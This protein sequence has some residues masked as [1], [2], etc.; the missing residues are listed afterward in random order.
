MGKKVKI[1]LACGSGIA[2][3]TVAA[4][5]VKKIAKAEGIEC[6]IIKCRV[7]ELISKAKNKEVDIVLSTGKIHEEQFEKPCMSV[8]GLI[9]GINEAKIRADLAKILHKIADADEE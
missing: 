5:V 2:T 4:D 9:S 3:S 7:Y 6:E 8:I 1:I